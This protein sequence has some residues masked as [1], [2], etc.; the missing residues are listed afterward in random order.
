MYNS[1]SPCA[2]RKLHGTHR[3]LPFLP[4]WMEQ[5]VRFFFIGVVNTL[6]G[7]ALYAMFVWFGLMP[8]LALLA[9]NV[10]SV[11]FAF[12]STGHF[13]YGRLGK[14][15]IRRYFTAWGFMYL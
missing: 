14:R 12:F 11:T 2:M 10:I 5:A 7:Y 4:L 1:T 6:L 15:V 9:G 8:A 3:L 13:V